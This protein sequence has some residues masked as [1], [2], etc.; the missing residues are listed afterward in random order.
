[1]LYRE[2]WNQVCEHFRAWWENERD[3]PLIQVVA[4]KKG[5]EG[6]QGWGAGD[7]PKTH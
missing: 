4:P 3:E 1:M 7:S 5:H 6:S 2:Y